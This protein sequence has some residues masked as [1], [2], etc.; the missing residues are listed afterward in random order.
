MLAPKDIVTYH[1]QPRVV[2]LCG[3]VLIGR[4]LGVGFFEELDI[5]CI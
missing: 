3:G 1:L 5:F 2:F 4:N